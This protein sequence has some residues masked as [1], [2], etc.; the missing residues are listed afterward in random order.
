MPS[1]C[2]VLPNKYQGGS[3]DFE[4]LEPCDLKLLAKVI[5]RYM[6]SPGVFADNHRCTANFLYSDFIGFDVDNNEGDIYTIEQAINDW[7][8]SECIIATTRNN[9]K[10]KV[11]DSCT[12]PPAP[13]FRIITKWESRICDA[14][15][16]QHTVRSFLKANT[17]Y[18]RACCD[19]ARMFYPC[20]G[21]V[22][23]NYDG[24]QQPVLDLPPVVK[25]PRLEKLL[26]AKQ[27]IDPT[28]ERF[29]KTGKTF[30]G[31]R[32]VA[33]Y[34]STLTMLRAGYPAEKV[35]ELIEQSPFSREQFSEF[36]LLRAYSNG[37]ETYI[38]ETKKIG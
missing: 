13:R 20:T 33:V 14:K 25:D 4:P 11:T 12:H 37:L 28:V 32:N 35:L 9:M 16:Y 6:W 2:R 1:F 27:G 38:N 18:D 15:V 23:Q 17:Q 31:G 30:G 10:E 29:L 26:N 8:D 5:Q 34:V 19:V 3:K 21:I 24:Y 22:F 36:E 7:C